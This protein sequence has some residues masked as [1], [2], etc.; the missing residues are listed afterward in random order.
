MP[1]PAN[2]Y[3]N[4]C[5]RKTMTPTITKIQVHGNDRWQV[6]YGIDPVT[7]KRL[8]PIF[9]SEEE[10][11][12][13]ID[14]T[15]K[16]EVKQGSWWV[17]LSDV[18]RKM[19]T[20][21]CAE[22]EAAGQTLSS[23]WEDWKKWRK[24]NQQIVVEPMPYDKAVDEWHRRKEVAGKSARY[25]RDASSMMMKLAKGKEKQMIHEFT[26]KDVEEF[27]DAHP[28]WSKSSR[29]TNM[30]I[31]SGLWDTA[32]K[33]GWCS[34]NVVDSLDPVGKIGREVSIYSYEETLNLMAGVMENDATSSRVLV[35]FTLGLFGCMRPEELQSKKAIELEKPLFDW[36]CID[37]EHGL[38]TVSKWVAKTGDQRT[39]R[40]QPVAVE[41]LKL[42][43][44]LE[45]PLPPINE[46]RL[47]A[48]V[49]ELIGFKVALQ[50]A[51]WERDGLRKNC[52][53]HLRAVYKNDYD[54][55][56]D[57]GNSVRILLK[58]Y[59]GLHTPESISLAHWKITPAVVEEYRKTDAWRQV[60]TKALT[61]SSTTPA[62]LA[63]EN[64]KT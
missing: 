19:I 33:K 2:E 37:L 17:R 43:K 6:Y 51:D 58:H 7:G 11:K 28:E 29:R 63:S 16:A 10:A 9:E 52:A 18:K 59:A 27:L 12:A 1:T 13:D 53:T 44:E 5:Q 57:M 64:G 47:R 25:L 54:V 38:V 42:A 21:V 3:A 60:L 62:P 14:K 48:S 40:L 31:F 46:R 8:R 35:V 34:I 61:A 22:V 45:N 20:A 32:V 39:I 56:K 23:V 24:D 30:S 36:S 4:G 49:C 50:D 41:W 26:S 15:A 55:V